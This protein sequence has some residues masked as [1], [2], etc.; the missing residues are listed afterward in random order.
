MGFLDLEI[1]R[2]IILGVVQGLT[3][4][5]PVS[6]SGH[7]VV[8]PYL[9]SWEEPGLA[10]NVALHAGTL[11]AVV[12]YFRAD[13]WYLATRS[14][15][16]RVTEPGEA[17]RARR[18]IAI[19]LVGTVPAAAAGLAFGETFER[20]FTE[21][22]W[23]AGFLLV[24]AGLLS[25]A[26]I[27]RRR[28]VERLVAAGEVELGERQDLTGV[29]AGRDETTVGWRDA[30]LI[31]A[32]QAGALLPGISRSGA[33]IAAGMALGLSRGGAARFSFLLSIPIIAGASVYEL[34]AL[35]A[36]G[37]DATEVFG[38]T[39]VLAGMVAAAASGYWAIRFL[40][41]LV[42]GSDLFGFVRYLVLIAVLVGIGR[43]WLGPPGVI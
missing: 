8:V 4:F 29:Q 38:P 2:A 40:L 31:G 12:A 5:L 10:F 3:E 34:P 23:V 28:R 42:Q 13:L 33:T 32:A 36:A 27:A 19:L 39:A 43:L 20:V 41:R 26:E 21:P 30:L 15:G 22:V 18:V 37:G 17:R 25:A 11:V 24:T 6:S 9:L 7:L 14:V 16:A 1:V 35:F